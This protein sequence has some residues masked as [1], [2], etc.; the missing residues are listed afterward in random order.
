MLLTRFWKNQQA[1]VAPLP[2]IA[3]I[4]MVGAVG[5]AVDYARASAA[6]TAFQ[7]SLDSTALMLS[8]T[9]ALQTNS[10][11]QT[12]ATNDVNALF[13]ATNAKNVA[14]T[15]AYSSTNGSQL[16]LNGSASINT[17]FLR[18]RPNTSSRITKL[19]E[20][21]ADGSKF[22]EGKSTAVEI[23]PVLGEAAAAIE[24]CNRTFYDPTLG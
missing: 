19:S 8:K 1:N 10:Q 7:A 24:P 17:N 9:A 23:F 11:L 15:V 14:V 6:R 4:P 21:E 22:Q 2:A 16:V 18:V 5:A 3:I 12:E 13:T 20:H